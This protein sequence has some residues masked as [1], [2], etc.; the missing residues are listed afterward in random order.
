MCPDILHS[1]Q[2]T[3][4]KISL[5]NTLNIDQILEADTRI[6]QFSYDNQDSILTLPTTQDQI[7]KDDNFLSTIIQS[8][9]SHNLAAVTERFARNL[10]FQ[11]A[12][13]C[14]VYY[15]MTSK[16]KND[17][18]EKTSAKQAALALSSAHLLKSL[19]SKSFGGSPKDY[20]AVQ[21]HDLHLIKIMEN[22]KDGSN[23]NFVLFK[24]ILY[25]KKT[26]SLTATYYVY[27][28]M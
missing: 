22:V 8:N 6:M 20:Q 7:Y 17:N 11:E 4:L 19:L 28:K 12:D 16:R 5:F 24:K 18:I 1:S 26:P 13:D 21:A 23:T 14:K 2:I 9:F 10:I 3:I 25:N 27:P 15:S